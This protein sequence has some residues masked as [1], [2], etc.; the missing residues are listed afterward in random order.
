MTELLKC[1]QPPTLWLVGASALIFLLALV[2][3]WVLF[4]ILR[5]VFRKEGLGKQFTKHLCYPALAVL[6]EIAAVI[7]INLLGIRSQFESFFHYLYSIVLIATIGWALAAFVH[8]IYCHTFVKYDSKELGDIGKRS[9]VTQIQ[10]LYRVVLFL[11]IILTIGTILL[12]FPHIKNIGIGIMGS[13][14]IIG[15]AVGIAARPIL[16]NLMAGFQIAFTRMLKIEDAV[17]VEGDFAR[18]EKIYLTHVVARTWDLRR[19]ILP[20]SYFIDKPFQNWSARTT[21]LIGTVFLYCDYTVPVEAVRKK[22]M[23]I[24]HSSELWN[25]RVAKVQV[26]DFT[27]RTMKLRIIMTA[28]DAPTAFNLRCEVREKLMELLQK[29]YP[30]ALP[31][32][33]S[34]NYES[35]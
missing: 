9:I 24:L 13:A 27:E 29:E 21:E 19:I 2:C 4:G 35:T 32:V 7:S 23:E 3:Y 22:F 26:V 25:K 31:C 5:K 18:I 20:I 15:I 17:I 6:L 1:L 33:R 34:V 14:G 30:H 10:L 28:H 16:L 8:A 11:I 12:T